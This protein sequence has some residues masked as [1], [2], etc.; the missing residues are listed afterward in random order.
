[1]GLGPRSA[2]PSLS[3]D[4]HRGFI[5]TY[6]NYEPGSFFVVPNREQLRSLSCYT[7]SVFINLCSRANNDGT[8]WPS[9]KK[10]AEDAGMSETKVKESLRELEKA[11][12]IKTKQRQMEN[13]G[14]SSNSYQ[15]LICEGGG[16]R[17]DPGVGRVAPSNDNQLERKIVSLRETSSPNETTTAEEEETT[18]VEC[19]DWGEEIEQK[20]SKKDP[21]T[22]A[23]INHFKK[24]IVRDLGTR[25][26]VA[27]AVARKMVNSALTHLTEP[28]LK[29]MISDWTA[30]GLPDHE[31]MQITR[32]L[33]TAQINKF[34]AERGIK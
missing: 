17:H 21:R 33:S 13:G 28:Q 27:L 20:K 2:Q 22:D 26:A 1:M 30:Q 5:I 34:K 7:Q 4:P 10:L 32:C 3:P 9:I 19:D 16:S 12:L 31:T 14:L 18:L 8:C 15:L 6:M 23:V 25:P 29:E 24:T 11:G